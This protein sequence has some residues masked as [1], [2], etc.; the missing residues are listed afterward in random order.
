MFVMVIHVAITGLVQ[1]LE[2]WLSH[3]PWDIRVHNVTVRYVIT[4][5]CWNVSKYWKSYFNMTVY[6]FNSRYCD[7]TLAHIPDRRL[8][9]I[10]LYFSVTFAYIT[11][12]YT[13]G[14]ETENFALQWVINDQ[15]WRFGL[16]LWYITPF[17]RI[18]Q[19]YRGGNRIHLYFSVTFAY[20]TFQYTCIIYHLASLHWKLC[21]K[22]SINN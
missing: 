1:Q 4:N 17:S 12:Q 6:A 9:T 13:K 5:M 22:Q 20:I 14:N 11:F 10:H 8:H 19:L 7:N 2:V 16:G 3:V 18:F 21:Y 15:S